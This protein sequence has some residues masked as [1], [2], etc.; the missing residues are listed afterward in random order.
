M[1]YKGPYCYILLLTGDENNRVISK[2]IYDGK[3][4]SFKT[5]VTKDRTPKIYI[6]KYNKQIVYIGYTS[7]S[8]SVRLYNGL[9]ATGLNGYHGYKWK[10]H[11]EIELL[12]FVFKQQLNGSKHDD[13][14]P[15]VNLAEAIEAELV[16]KVRNETGLWPAY[17]NEI[18]FNN[19]QLE[20]AKKIAA[21]IYNLVTGTQN[22]SSKALK[23]K[24][25]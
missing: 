6:L 22:S 25:N 16:Y 5:P 4:T 1:L 9:K 13:D 18:H 11:D 20:N 14:K 23:K 24:F 3:E 17:Q 15:Y 21:D 8:I 10:K 7:Q 12:V 19:V 2:K